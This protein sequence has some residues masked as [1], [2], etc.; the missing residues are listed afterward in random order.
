MTALSLVQHSTQAIA[1]CL[2]RSTNCARALADMQ[3]NKA[4]HASASQRFAFATSC[5]RSTRRVKGKHGRWAGVDSA[6]EQYKLEA[7]KLLENGAK[8]SASSRSPR[9][10]Q[11]RRGAL[12]W[13][14][15]RTRCW[16]AFHCGDSLL[17]FNL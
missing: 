15:S 3:R 5:P 8:S 17:L 9:E 12:S 11:R 7:R 4:L 16:L 1:D 2:E 13:R 6:W 14:S 10:A